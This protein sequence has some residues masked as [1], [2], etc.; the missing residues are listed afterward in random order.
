MRLC[1]TH[2][3]VLI[4][5]FHCPEPLQIIQ[6]MWG[7]WDFYCKVAWHQSYLGIY[8]SSWVTR[9]NNIYFLFPALGKSSFY[10]NM[11]IGGHW[12][13]QWMFILKIMNLCDYDA[14]TN[15]EFIAYSFTFIGCVEF[16]K[17]QKQLVIA[18]VF[19]L[20]LSSESQVQNSKS[21]L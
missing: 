17:Y 11:Q 16:I 20:Y 4:K 14:A 9:N 12:F 18:K 10:G 2:K 3:G 19:T 8:Y 13:F 1:D 5:I 15:S 6:R 21:Q 7:D